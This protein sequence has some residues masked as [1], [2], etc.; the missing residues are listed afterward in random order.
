MG[1]KPSDT[2]LVGDASKNLRLFLAWR[3]VCLYLVHERARWAGAD[4]RKT[5][6]R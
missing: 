2:S 6:E 1:C 4:W 3:S 5:C